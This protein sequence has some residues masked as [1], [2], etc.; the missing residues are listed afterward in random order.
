M[1]VVTNFGENSNGKSNLDHNF[2]FIF[3]WSA[4]KALPPGLNNKYRKIKWWPA[5][6]LIRTSK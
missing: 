1:Q 4:F 2:I 3:I 6:N 5:Q